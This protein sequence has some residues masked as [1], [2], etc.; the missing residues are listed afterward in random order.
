MRK[1]NEMLGKALLAF[2]NRTSPR[3]SLNQSSYCTR[4][5]SFLKNQHPRYLWQQ[6]I[7][8]NLSWKSHWLISL[9]VQI[10]GSLTS[11]RKRDVPHSQI[12]SNQKYWK[13]WTCHVPKREAYHVPLFYIEDISRLCRSDLFPV[14]VGF[15]P[16]E[17]IPLQQNTKRE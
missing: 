7:P 3:Y 10:A 6:R 2:K 15:H 8:S 17:R 11:A 5:K 16:G 14:A 13:K 4:Y 1:R 9:F 12:D